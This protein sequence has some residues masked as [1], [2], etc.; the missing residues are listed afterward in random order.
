VVWFTNEAMNKPHHLKDDDFAQIIRHAPLVSID[1]IIRDD[2][3]NLFVGLRANE[4]A[5]DY[6]FVPGGV[7][8]KNET[9]GN[10]FK[11]ILETET[12]CRAPLSDAK[13]FGVFEHL[14]ETNRFGSPDYGTHYVVLAY[15]LKLGHRPAFELDSQHSACRWMSEAEILSAT[16]VHP[17]T[18]AYIR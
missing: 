3:R 1:I 14:Y 5:R 15:E 18:K 7:I 13:L 2:E 6:Y 16:T 11:R 8:R 4:P 17:N 10:A 12:G 9:I